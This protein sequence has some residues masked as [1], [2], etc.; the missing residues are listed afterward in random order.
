MNEI[1][2]FRLVWTEIAFGGIVTETEGF[3]NLVSTLVGLESNKIG[4]ETP[5]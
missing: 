5:A 1:S 4:T 3:E 2:E